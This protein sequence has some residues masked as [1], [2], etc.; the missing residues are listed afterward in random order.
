VAG[1]EGLRRIMQRIWIQDAVMFDGL[2]N[3]ANMANLARQSGELQSRMAEVKDRISRMEVEGLGGGDA[4]QV[5]MSGDFQVRSVVIHPWLIEA[6]NQQLMQ[7]LTQDA[8][9]AALQKAREMAAAEMARLAD[10]L[11]IPGMQDALSR[12]G[13]S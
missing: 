11:K 4:V 7:Q 3:L 9:N 10:E 1:P 12:M 13:L 8:F 6:R 5:R 2:K